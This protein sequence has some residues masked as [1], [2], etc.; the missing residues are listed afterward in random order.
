SIF[1]GGF[2]L[3]VLALYLIFPS[4][5]IGAFS[6]D[7]TVHTIGAEYLRIVGATYVFLGTAVVLSQALAGAGATMAS[8]AIDSVVLCLL[9][10][11]ATLLMLAFFDL[12]RVETWLLIAAGNVLS[13]A[14]YI[15]WYRRGDWLRKII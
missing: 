11:P 12:S 2:M 8:F 6:D 3:G 5:I 10:I 4:A 14:A 9:L 1:N 13:C 7:P 15:V